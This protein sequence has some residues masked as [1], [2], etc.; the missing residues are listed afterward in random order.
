MANY[1]VKDTQLTSIAN[2]IRS[3]VGG[4]QMVFPNGF[5][6]RING[7]TAT[8]LKRNKTIAKTFSS[9]TPV[10]SGAMVL[11]GTVSSSTPVGAAKSVTFS[12]SGGG[13]GLN[14]LEP[15]VKYDDGYGVY[16]FNP[17]T[18][19]VVIGANTKATV[20]YEEYYATL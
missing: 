9:Q 17:K 16:L 11:V 4:Q 3:K 6:S 20:T 7:I 12:P 19:P 14:Y 10:A 18:S 1:V 5:V 13:S 8:L 15:C 2:A